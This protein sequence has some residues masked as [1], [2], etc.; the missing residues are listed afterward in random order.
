M[1]RAASVAT[2]VGGSAR[3][4]EDGVTRA[5]GA[6]GPGRARARRSS[7]RSSDP[8]RR[9]RARAA[10]EEVVARYA[11]D[12][13]ADRLSRVYERLRSPRQRTRSESR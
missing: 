12:P 8:R 11:L 13:V 3:V 6:R 2:A 5:A 10:R 1:R 9:L 4:L 7:K